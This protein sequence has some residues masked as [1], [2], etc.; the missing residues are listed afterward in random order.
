MR[1]RVIGLLVSIILIG[2]CL[3]CSHR[4]AEEEAARCNELAFQW[5]YRN[6][7][8]SLTYARSALRLATQHG[9]EGAAARCNLAYIAYQ[10]MAYEKSM[11]LLNQSYHCTNDQIVLLCAD[12]L[13]MKVAQKT[14]DG[15][16]FF[17]HRNHALRRI[18]RIFEER[19]RLTPKQQKHFH[20]A[21]TELH[22]V[23]S[24]YYYYLGQ[25]S[26][27]RAEIHSID[28]DVSL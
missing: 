28:T 14:G 20:Y 1:G 13:A 12:V 19:D 27:A 15:Y 7:D 11:R 22:I 5:R 6:I 8:S 23:S 25:D 4:E 2:T 17:S 16:S 18:S 9:A 26:A 21:L 10:Q 3:S 24:T